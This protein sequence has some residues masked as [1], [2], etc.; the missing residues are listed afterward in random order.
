VP[1]LGGHWGSFGKAERKQ[2][3]LFRISQDGGKSGGSMCDFIGVEARGSK[4]MRWGSEMLKGGKGGRR[5]SFFV[6]PHMEHRQE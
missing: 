5:S 4:G 2:G 3:T 6:G 1:T